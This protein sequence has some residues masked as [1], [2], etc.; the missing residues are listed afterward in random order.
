MC[1]YIKTDAGCHRGNN[2]EHLHEEYETG[3]EN[4]MKENNNCEKEVQTDRE[5]ELNASAKI[6]V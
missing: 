5:K 2:C 3:K 1:R 6:N 4:E